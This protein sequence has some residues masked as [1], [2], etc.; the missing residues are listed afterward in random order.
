MA[1]CYQV[2]RFTNEQVLRDLDSVVR[3]IE[4]VVLERL[5]AGR[6]EEPSP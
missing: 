2:I 3:T 4:A 6:K 1:Q 5:A